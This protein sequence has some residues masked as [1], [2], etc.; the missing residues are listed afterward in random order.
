MA[1]IKKVMKP[2]VSQ[3]RPLVARGLPQAGYA[4]G[5]ATGVP[6]GGMFGKELGARLAKIVG[7]GDYEM[8]TAVNSLFKG[9]GELP[10]ASFGSD[11]STIR[12]RRREFLAD[13]K[14][15]SVAGEF[16]NYAY[17][18]NAGIRETFPFFVPTSF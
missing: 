10:S 9:G 18:I 8:N 12:I 11:A 6:Y 14:T 2:M 17:S 16:V 3:L 5:N 15:S 4:I 13:L 7:S 1:D